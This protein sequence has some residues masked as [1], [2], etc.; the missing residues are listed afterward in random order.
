MT[1]LTKISD[2]VAFHTENGQKVP[3]EGSLYYRGIDVRALVEGFMAE[4]RFGYEETVYLLLFGA[5]PTKVS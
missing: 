3:C 1:G 5:L 2:I 4:K